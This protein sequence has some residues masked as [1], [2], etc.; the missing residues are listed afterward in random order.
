MYIKTSD[1]NCNILLYNENSILIYNDHQK[2][3]KIYKN[4]LNNEYLYSYKN[5]FTDFKYI[6]LCVSKYKHYSITESYCL[7]CGS[8]S[9]KCDLYLEKCE[10]YSEKFE[11]Y[12][13]KNGSYIEKYEEY[14]V[15]LTFVPCII[16]H[17]NN[18]LCRL[19]YSFTYSSYLENLDI[20]S[21]NGEKSKEIQLNSTLLSKALSDF[22]SI[23]P[24]AEI[25]S[26]VANSFEIYGYSKTITEYTSYFDI[27]NM[28]R[29][30][31]NRINFFKKIGF[32][33]IKKDKQNIL[34]QNIL[35]SKYFLTIMEQLSERPNDYF[36][37]INA[38]KFKKNNL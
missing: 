14:L 10:L 29:D 18:G 30:N 2:F 8:Y 13:Q 34:N 5:T 38:K 35:E 17:D 37:Y 20:L 11:L 31:L 32:D 4:V 21:I 6:K 9:E 23:Y 12:P 33:I 7:K 26:P 28:I 3:H 36:I 15:D 25:L 19:I 24:N 22:F 16:I 1:N 27:Y